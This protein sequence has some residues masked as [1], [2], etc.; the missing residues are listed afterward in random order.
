MSGTALTQTAIFIGSA[1]YAA[2]FARR[3]STI[4]EVAAPGVNTAATPAGFKLGDIVGRNRAAH[5]H[6]DIPRPALTEHADDPRH[7]R[8]VRPREDRDPDGVGILLDRR[9]DDLLGR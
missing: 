2:T 3:K 8:H 9:L 6:E 1:L 4:S 5:Q 7:E